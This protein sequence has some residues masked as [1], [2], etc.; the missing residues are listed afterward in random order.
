MLLT[1]GL[2]NH[3][4]PKALFAR[5]APNDDTIVSAAVPAEI[6]ER[7]K[8]GT[9]LIVEATADKYPSISRS[10][11]NACASSA[12]APTWRR[13]HSA[14]GLLGTDATG[15]PVLDR[16]VPDDIRSGTIWRW[17]NALWVSFF[18]SPVGDSD[19]VRRFLGDHLAR[20][21]QCVI[22]RGR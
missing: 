12:P 16:D 6:V 19:S 1:R 13:R 2:G 21:V 15:L 10:S 7:G 20:T 3:Y 11:G 4:G 8:L 18:Y 9:T 5:N 22:A 17:T 14:T